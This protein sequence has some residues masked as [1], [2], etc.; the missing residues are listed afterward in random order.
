MKKITYKGMRKMNNKA[1]KVRYGVVF[2]LFITVIVNYM[3]RSNISIAA[4]FIT[5]EL[6]IDS[7]T[8][9]LIFSAVGWTYCGLQ[10]PGG[11][12]L[13]KLGNRNTHAVGIAGFSIMTLL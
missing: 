13:D 4:P 11:W 2:M 5:K 6:G 3:D 1:T 9:G 8:M 7:V 10:I 12:V